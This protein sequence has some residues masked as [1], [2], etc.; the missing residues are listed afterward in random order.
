[1]YS[2]L[3]LSAKSHHDP[4]NK[5][6]ACSTLVHRARALYDEDSLQAELVFLRDIFKLNGYNKQQIHK[7]LNHHP[8]V[9]QP[10]NKPNSVAFLPSVGPIFN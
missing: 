9:G 5:Q 3:Y 10:D 1:M 2:N 7:A 4:F 8:D 6:A